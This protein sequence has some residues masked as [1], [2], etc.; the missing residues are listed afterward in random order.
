MSQSI[1]LELQAHLLAELE[2]YRPQLEEEAA[3]IVTKRRYLDFPLLL[4][5]VVDSVRFDTQE[6]RFINLQATVARTGLVAAA[7]LGDHAAYC[8]TYETVMIPL[9]WGAL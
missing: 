5:N 3:S 2:R 6:R 1:S 9:D 7:W 8:D 4:S